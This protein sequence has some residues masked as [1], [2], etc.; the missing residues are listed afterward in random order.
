[1][2]QSGAD[3]DERNKL[4]LRRQPSL[5][6]PQSDRI[7]RREDEDEGSSIDQKSAAAL[8]NQSTHTIYSYTTYDPSETIPIPSSVSV[9]DVNHSRVSPLGNDSPMAAFFANL[10]RRL[11]SGF[12]FTPSAA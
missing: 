1:M 12:S 6:Q 3:Y 11:R 9:L 7:V 10:N 4:R 2:K 5:S 8:F